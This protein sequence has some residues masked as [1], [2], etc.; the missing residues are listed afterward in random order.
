ML[1]V[2]LGT[3]SLS[4]TLKT[5][6]R[7][8]PSPAPAAAAESTP[9]AAPAPAAAP[10]AASAPPPPTTKAS[11]RGK[12]GTSSLTAGQGA[13]QPAR[14]STAIP[15]PLPA[16]PAVPPVLNVK[17]TGL[18]G[19]EHDLSA[20]TGV[21]EQAADGFSCV[22]SDSGSS[23]D[24]EPDVEPSAADVRLQQALRRYQHVVLD[25]KLSQMLATYQVTQ[26]QSDEASCDLVTGF[27]LVDGALRLV[28]LEGPAAG[29]GMGE[30][31]PAIVRWALEDQQDWQQQRRQQEGGHEQEDDDWLPRR[32]VFNPSIKYPTRLYAALGV[33]LWMVKL[34]APLTVIAA[35]A[36][37]YASGRVKPEC[38]AGMESL[39]GLTAGYQKPGPQTSKATVREGHRQKAGAAV[40]TSRGGGRKATSRM[41][42][43][44]DHSGG[45]LTS[46]S[47]S[48]TL[49]KGRASTAGDA[50]WTSHSGSGGSGDVL[51]QS[52]A[53]GGPSATGGSWAISGAA[54]GA[55]VVKA[56]ACSVGELTPADVLGVELDESRRSLRSMTS[57]RGG[58][59]SKQRRRRRRHQLKRPSDASNEVYLHLRLEGQRQRALRNY[60]AENIQALPAL[61]DSKQFL[62]DSWSSWNPQRA[63]AQQLEQDIQDG[64]LT[65]QD[66][67]NAK[68]QA[69]QEQDMLTAACSTS[70][71]TQSWQHHQ[72]QRPEGAVPHPAPFLWPAP[73]DPASY[74]V[75][76]K[77]PSG[78]RQ[79]ELQQPW[80]EVALLA[81]RQDFAGSV[82]AVPGSADAVNE[83]RASFNTVLRPLRD[84]LFTQDHAFWKTVHLGGD[85]WDQQQTEAAAAAKAEW[86]A[87]LVV[88]DPVLHVVPGTGDKAAAQADRLSNLLKGAPVK[89]G[90]KVAY[91]PAAPVSM[92]LQV[93]WQPAVTAAS[94]GNGSSTG[95]GVMATHRVTAAE[96]KKWVCDRD[97]DATGVKQ[98]SCLAKPGF[99]DASTAALHDSGYKKP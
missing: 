11:N 61:A 65:L 46:G 39:L 63:A 51:C 72:Q 50:V 2:F 91:S 81:G 25:T 29:K 67:V 38:I 89:K 55:A 30:V 95:V 60:P 5:K 27:H 3:C 79:E 83:A 93:P 7:D 59:R 87:R 85:G 22:G 54:T 73:R 13:E 52:Q 31:V 1:G 37:T 84:G 75:H 10:G 70:T 78:F 53:A 15:D 23:S 97:F 64:R 90:F 35:Q 92:Q 28:V 56:A 71:R 49:L 14:T 88:K 32:V 4:I 98:R 82:P 94:G 57:S 45:Q 16:S 34:R 8:A 40:I 76:P 18:Q 33:E 36:A 26:A 58:S 20:V 24:D 42:I 66:T 21:T 68:R 12:S 44:G 96:N 47:G 80:D 77:R 99:S 86:A 62:R 41:S 48:A 43:S 9:P 74:N 17:L 69:Q 19:L 6:L